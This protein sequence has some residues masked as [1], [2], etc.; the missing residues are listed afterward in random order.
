M[1]VQVQSNGAGRISVNGSL[2]FATA[3]TALESGVAL[4]N[5]SEPREVDLSALQTADSAGLAV[6]LEWYRQA[7]QRQQTIR[8]VGVPAT[9]RALAKI[10]DLDRLLNFEQ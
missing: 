4:L 8:F 10:S 3:R 5:G 7:A 6:L 1:S 9:L 2:I